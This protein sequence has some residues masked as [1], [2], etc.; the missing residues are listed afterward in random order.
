M[1]RIAYILLLLLL[2][3]CSETKKESESI[4]IVRL[5]KMLYNNESVPDS[6]L[7]PML[8]IFSSQIGEEYNAI[9]Y[10]NSNFFQ[11]FE[12]DVLD[13]LPLLSNVEHDLSIM[14]SNA[15]NLSLSLPTKNYC[16]IINPYNQSII[17][18]DSIVYIGLNHYLGYDYK[19]YESFPDYIRKRKDISRMIYD[20]VESV[21]AYYYP[22]NPEDNPTVL[23]KI[24]YEGALAYLATKLIPRCN[25]FSYLSYDKHEIRWIKENS[26]FIWN[27]IV[28][29]QLLFTSD[30]III[31]KLCN[32]S[33]SSNVICDESPAMI[34]RY[35]GYE[36]VSAY[37][38]NNPVSDDCFI[39]YP[40][41]YNAK[42]I[43]IKAK[44][45]L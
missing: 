15:N 9:N 23:S 6:L 3:S 1:K 22:Y 12:K 42:D 8:S 40:E 35:I 34:G 43:L 16:G 18:A 27:T 5:D 19:G 10:V 13:K 11:I 37:L 24:V 30:H 26:S 2:L 41:F 28:E 31:S 38:K 14:Y 21:L 36:I 17:V 39:L 25:V 32:V 33:P 4:E 29:K 7:K 45:S 20:I 44:F